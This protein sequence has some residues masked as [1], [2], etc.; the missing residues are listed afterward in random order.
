MRNMDV[1]QDGNIAL[2]CS[3]VNRVFSRATRNLTLVE[4]AR[5]S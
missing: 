2:A 5:P 4:M 1:T 3:G